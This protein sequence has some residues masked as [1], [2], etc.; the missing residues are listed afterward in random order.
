M[1]GLELE[2]I[3]VGRVFGLDEDCPPGLCGGGSLL[4]RGLGEGLDCRSMS[5]CGGGDGCCS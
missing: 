1:V 3:G 2:R 4:D 5:L